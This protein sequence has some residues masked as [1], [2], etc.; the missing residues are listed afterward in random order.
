MSDGYQIDLTA[1]RAAADGIGRAVGQ[2]SAHPVASPPDC[3]QPAAPDA[4]PTPMEDQMKN[5]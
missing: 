3:V 2:V 4:A 1:L 5:R